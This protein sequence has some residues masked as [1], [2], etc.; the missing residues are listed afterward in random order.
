M[1]LTIKYVPPAYS[2]VHDDLIYTVHEPGH[3]SDPSNYPNYKYI[4][5]VYIG[6][7]LVARIRK[8]QDP[9]TGI[10]IFNIGQ[11]VRNYINTVFNPTA[12][13]LVAQQMGSGVF[14]VQV[15]VKF[16]EEYA[17]TSYYDLVSDSP[18]VY[19]NNYNGRLIGTS[20]SLVGI[21]N[22]VATS[23]PQRGE[24]LLT[25]S[26]NFIGYFPTSTS[27]V[28]VSVIPNDNGNVFNGNFTP[29]N[30]YD[31]QVLNFSPVLINSL[32]PGTITANTEY[33][34]VHIADQSFRFKVI[35]E[36]L[37]QP[38]TLH[39]LNKFGAWDTKIFSKV[40]RKKINIEKKQYGKID[41][42]V[43]SNGQVTYKNANGVYHESQ[44]TYS[45][46]FEET[47]ILNSDY[48]TDQEYTWLEQLIESTM[49]YLQEGAYFF[50]VSIK[51]NN[52]DPKKAVVDQLTNLTL[53]VEFG[54]QYNA[55]FR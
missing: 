53:T 22:K 6:A 36:P 16:G 2:S 18:R 25:S 45:S 1:A 37:Y 21:T 10:G 44:T 9:V 51:Q 41:Y 42:V 39:F 26:F 52:Y 46:Q 8:V 30:A 7:T 4:A 48:L 31:M 24:V 32:Q 38:Y 28:N 3:V 55:Q 29:S 35:C 50:P 23:R 33:Y 20:S 11:T 13:I 47:L 12:N 14:N 49:V 17:F 43:D 27:T 40:S 15:T 34:T 5:D 54:K 19:F